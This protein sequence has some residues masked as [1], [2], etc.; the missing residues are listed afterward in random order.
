M[1]QVD[2][3]TG[4]SLLKAGLHRFD[5]SGGKAHFTCCTGM[6][7][8]PIR[9]QPLLRGGCERIDA[10]TRA[11]SGSPKGPAPL[12]GEART[13]GR[14][15]A[16]SVTPHTPA[17]RQ[18]TSCRCRISS[19]RRSSCVSSTTCRSRRTRDGDCAAPHRPCQPCEL[20]GLPEGG[21]RGAREPMEVPASSV[22]IEKMFGSFFSK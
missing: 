17:R 14:S 3:A 21:G 2:L 18:S 11:T 15:G 6:Q 1:A 22:L 4:S 12:P 7:G 13:K 19:R 5:S 10:E 8:C 16:P 20:R 9:V